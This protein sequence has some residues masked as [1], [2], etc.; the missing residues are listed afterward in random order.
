MGAI[1]RSDLRDGGIL[2]VGVSQR[3]G[4]WERTGITNEHLRSFGPD[5]IASHLSAFISPHI[6]L[7]VVIVSHEGK[8]YLAIYI[9]EF[10]DTPLVCKKNGP[11]RSRIVEGRVPCR[12]SLRGPLT[13]R[14]L[15]LGFLEGIRAT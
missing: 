1:P 12:S 6:S 14:L 9:R 15:G 11:D 10:D 2:I 8:E 13:I 3:D 4:R 7:D 5:N